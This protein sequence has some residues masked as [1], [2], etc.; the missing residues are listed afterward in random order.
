MLAIHGRMATHSGKLIKWD[1]AFNSDLS[2]SPAAYTWDAEP[3]V[4]P[5]AN[6]NYPIPMPGTT[7]VL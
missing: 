2:L 6:G 4:L 5:D 3:P 1:D 7:E